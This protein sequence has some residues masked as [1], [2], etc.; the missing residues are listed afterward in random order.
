MRPIL[1]T[2]TFVLELVAFFGFA[3]FGYTFNISDSAQIMSF[4]ALLTVLVIFWARYM[5]P[6]APC[7]ISPQYAYAARALI[8]GAAGYTLYVLLHS[9]AAAIFI[10]VW[11]ADEILLRKYK[12]HAGR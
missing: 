7:P 5:S 10:C 1:F 12:I 6:R 11:L 4:A 8:Y 2:L 3:A 9:N